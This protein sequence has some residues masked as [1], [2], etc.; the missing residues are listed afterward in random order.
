MAMNRQATNRRSWYEPNG[1]A[2]S[3]STSALRERWK[4]NP[5]LTSE[6]LWTLRNVREL[7]KNAPTISVKVGSKEEQLVDLRGFS[8]H[9]NDMSNVD[10]SY[11]CFDF[12]DFRNC[13]FTGTSLQ[14]STF[15]YS[16][17]DFAHLKNVQASPVSLRGASMRHALVTGCFMMY[18]DL[19][20]AD[21]SGSKWLNSSLANSDLREIVFEG[22]AFEQIDLRCAFMSD[23]EIARRWY[24][25]QEQ[26]KQH[27]PAW[28]ASGC[29][30][31]SGNDNAS[32]MIVDDS[33]T[34][35][36]VLSNRLSKLGYRVL[37]AHNGQDAIGQLRRTVPNLV[38]LDLE[39]PKMG[40]L[41]VM[42]RLREGV[43]TSALPVVIFTALD[44]ASL[45]QNA[46]EAGAT[47]Y[48][49]KPLSEDLIARIDEL[50]ASQ[51]HRQVVSD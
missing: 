24:D 39:M 13:T 6:I 48:F 40:G 2:D 28:L 11:C 29:P 1:P 25:E 19:N 16:C 3:I 12:S 44:D 8:F 9:E 34:T 15:R 30:R 43:A 38:I 35:R 32:I 4:A 51:H 26:K 41:E 22:A 45:R 20:S 42:R 49:M 31:K 10:L 47:D 14:Y 37:L 21:L 7:P 36:E 46:V 27:G 23:T 18:S 17:L 5:E 33:A 50:V